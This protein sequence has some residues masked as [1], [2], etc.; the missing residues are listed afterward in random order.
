MNISYSRNV[1][2]NIYGDD[3]DH[4]K[5]RVYIKLGNAKYQI[6]NDKLP[7]EIIDGSYQ[8]TVFHFYCL[9]KF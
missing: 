3:S 8:I 4:F 5:V 6:N 1:V 7:T 9:V 2:N